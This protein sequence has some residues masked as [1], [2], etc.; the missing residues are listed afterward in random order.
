MGS[1]YMEHVMGVKN[2]TGGNCE[3]R[4]GRRE[5]KCAGQRDIPTFKRMSETL[6][7]SEVLK[8]EIFRTEQ[9]MS[10]FVKHLSGNIILKLYEGVGATLLQEGEKG[11]DDIFA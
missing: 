1:I 4:C 5:G 10:S 6:I 8:Q 7:S 9:Q 11:H 2:P 3:Y